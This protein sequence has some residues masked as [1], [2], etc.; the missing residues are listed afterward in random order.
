MAFV[1]VKPVGTGLK[2]GEPLAQAETIKVTFDIVSPVEGT[3][4]AANAKLEAEPEL[5]NEHPY[6]DG[7]LAEIDLADPDA[8]R[9][10]LLDA[11]AFFEV[12]K[13]H[14]NA[15]LLK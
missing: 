10:G 11:P 9:K 8:A 5:V 7:W 14:A 12:M 1:S 4:V 15:E 13:A 3:I 2:A 6:D